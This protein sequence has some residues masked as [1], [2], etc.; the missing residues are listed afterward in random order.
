MKFKY[1]GIALLALGFVACESDDM[2]ETAA[3]E[4][5]VALTA[6]EMPISPIMWP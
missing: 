5:T 6:G 3:P 4:Q 1:L 2:T